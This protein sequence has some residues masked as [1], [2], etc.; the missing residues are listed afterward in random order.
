[1]IRRHATHSSPGASI[2]CSFAG[3]LPAWL[4][5]GVL[6]VFAGAHR[7]VARQTS[8]SL[9]Q[10]ASKDA[11]PELNSITVEA[12]RER[13]ALEHQVDSFVW[14]V[15]VRHNADNEGLSRWNEPICPFVDGLRQ[16]Q[17]KFLVARLSEIAVSAGAQLAREP[18]KPNFFVVATPEPEVFLKKWYARDPRMFNHLHGVGPIR[19]F[20]GTQ[21]PVRVW[22]NRDF[23]SGDGLPA[24][25]QPL[26][27]VGGSGTGSGPTATANN[28]Y[29]IIPLHKGTRLEWD[30]VQNLTL[31][32][33]VVDTTRIKNLSV[34]QLADY[35]SMVGLAEVHLDAKIESAASILNLFD[36]TQE[37]LP[38]AL[39]GWDQAFLKSVYDTNQRSVV[40][41]S[42]IEEHML[43]DIAH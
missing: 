31:A 33:V 42:E 16:E 36:A 29:P 38:P 20:I 27:L 19:N 43:N 39:T 35:I 24:A 3:D 22:Y 40:Q 34:G 9:P 18:C 11:K 28:T 4:A 12:Q 17:G 5:I 37:T 6:A 41:L 10:A 23:A 8:D 15:L 1:M 25:D 32:I 2:R 7:V 14:S 21:R 13:K 26:P 30:G